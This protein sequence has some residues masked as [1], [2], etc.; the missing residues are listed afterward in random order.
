MEKFPAVTTDSLNYFK[1]LLEVC[2]VA[3]GLNRELISEITFHL[4]GY[5][6]G[7]VDHSK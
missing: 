5:A 4:N 6:H 7:K 3:G 2:L 1:D